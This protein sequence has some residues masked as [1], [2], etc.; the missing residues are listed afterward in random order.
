MALR[1]RKLRVK[2]NPSCFD[3]S[4]VL[5]PVCTE[6][7]NLIYLGIWY[8]VGSVY[9][10]A[11]SAEHM[12]DIM[13]TKELK[14]HMVIT[15][16]ALY[17]TPGGE[18]QEEWRSKPVRANKSIVV[19][20][21]TT[22][23]FVHPPGKESLQHINSEFIADLLKSLPGLDVFYKF[24]L[25]LYSLEQNMNFRACKGYNKVRLCRS[26]DGWTTAPKEE[27]YVEILQ[28]LVKKTQQAVNM[29]TGII[30]PCYID[31]F[32]K[33]AESVLGYKDSPVPEQRKLYERRRNKVLNNIAVHVTDNLNRL[34][35]WSGKKRKLVY[36]APPTKL[37]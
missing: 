24:G 3:L 6:Y 13:L 23:V 32:E 34:S 28:I 19:N 1:H 37:A 36:T 15:N 8:H 4:T 5:E 27:A 31:H 33:H 21:D 30:P 26:R 18:L 17:S 29:F 12:S 2:A 25:K 11:Q 14:D 7:P 35:N 9:V 22:A 10:Y 20:A 16:I